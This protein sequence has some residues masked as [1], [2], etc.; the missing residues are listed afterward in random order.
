MSNDNSHNYN[1][2]YRENRPYSGYNGR[3]EGSQRS[4]SFRGRPIRDYHSGNR[5]AYNPRQPFGNHYRPPHPQKRIDH[6]SS[7]SGHSSRDRLEP[8]QYFEE[9]LNDSRSSSVSQHQVVESNEFPCVEVKY[10]DTRVPI[11]P[12]TYEVIKEKCDFN[13]HICV[14]Y[15]YVLIIYK[16]NLIHKFSAIL[17]SEQDTITLAGTIKFPEMP[18]LGLKELNK[19][20]SID[21]TQKWFGVQ[22]EFPYTNVTYGVQANFTKA[23]K[24]DYKLIK[25]KDFYFEEE[26]GN[27]SILKEYPSFGKW[28]LDKNPSEYRFVLFLQDD[29]NLQII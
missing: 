26:V 8:L 19:N 21:T 15:K 17:N 10:F 24:T 14:R 23:I 16:N 7:Y 27:Q 11:D 5:T 20:I 2:D 22:P 28:P 9:E 12:I 25:A 3:S 13:K 18:T 6:Y 29:A 4:H 1:R